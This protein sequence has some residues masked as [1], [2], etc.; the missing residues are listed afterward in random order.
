MKNLKK[1]VTEV[2]IL[3]IYLLFPFII[4]VIHNTLK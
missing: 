1:T 3:P 2:F 4:T